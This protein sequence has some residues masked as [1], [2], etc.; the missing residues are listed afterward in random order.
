MWPG[1]GDGDGDGDNPPDRPA[2]SSAAAGCSAMARPAAAPATAPGAAGVTDK[3]APHLSSALPPTSLCL[4]TQTSELSPGEPREAARSRLVVRAVHLHAETT[5]QA[6]GSGFGFAVKRAPKW[7]S[8]L[9]EFQLPDTGSPQT[10]RSQDGQT[11]L[12][13]RGSFA[14]GGTAHDEPQCR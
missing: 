3:A 9:P 14:A 5:N 1:R 11:L 12:L 10:P 6:A 2:P 8:P 7:R 4:R 13:R